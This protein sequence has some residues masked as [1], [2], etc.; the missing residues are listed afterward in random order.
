MCN[1]P[2][3]SEAVADQPPSQRPTL[4]SRSTLVSGGAL[5]VQRNCRV[6]PLGDQWRHGRW[7]R[8]TQGLERL[9]VDGE[10][11]DARLLN[12]QI[13]GVGTLE[14]FVDVHRDAARDRGYRR[15]VAHQETCVDE[16]KDII[17]Y[18]R[19]PMLNRELGEP[20]S[21]GLVWPV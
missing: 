2:G 20:R 7:D 16:A 4:L 13:A 6:D 21:D 12:R 3:S 1:V 15:A 9:D 5:S 14:Y 11:E 19:H 10:I 18:A 8:Q 17:G